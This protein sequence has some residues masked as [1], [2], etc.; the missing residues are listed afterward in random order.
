MNFHN[1]LTCRQNGY[2]P[3]HATDQETPQ[4]EML[5]LPS[6]IWSVWAKEE[7]GPL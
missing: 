2:F 3:L 6:E 4:P 1:N 5:Q 7:A